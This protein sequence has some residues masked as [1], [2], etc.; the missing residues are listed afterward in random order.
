[1]AKK[2]ER[3]D[4]GSQKAANRS[5]AKNKTLRRQN[6]NVQKMGNMLVCTKCIR[7]LAKQAA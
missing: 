4:K 6:V 2:C 5:H 7:T 3:C 1:M